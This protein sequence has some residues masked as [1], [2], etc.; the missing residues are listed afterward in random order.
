M[1]AEI[2]TER[3]FYDADKTKLVTEDDPEARI[4]AAA[5]GDEIPEGFKVPSSK[6]VGKAEDKQADAPA[7]KGGIT[8]KK[9]S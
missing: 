4:L 8:I 1:S 5:A 3:L 7:N 6:K 2:A 9:D